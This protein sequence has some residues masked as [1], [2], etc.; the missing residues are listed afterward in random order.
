MVV[1]L[2]RMHAWTGSP[3]MTGAIIGIGLASRHHPSSITWS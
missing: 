3:S 2:E 1:P